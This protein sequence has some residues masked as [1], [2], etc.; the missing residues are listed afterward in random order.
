M[1]NRRN[2][3][4]MILASLS[5]LMMGILVLCNVAGSPRFETF[6]TLDVIRL[7]AAGA[8]IGASLVI[9]VQLFVFRG[10]RSEEKEA[11]VKSGRE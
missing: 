1:R 5:S 6:H 3:V 4:P 7:V 11:E 2:S 8:G 10:D 9:L